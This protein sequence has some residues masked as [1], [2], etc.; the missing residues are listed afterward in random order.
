MFTVFD[1]LL[2]VGACSV[3]ILLIRLLRPADPSLE[4]Y[5]YL[6]AYCGPAGISVFGPWAVRRQFLE[7][8]REQLFPGEW[9][10]ITLGGAWLAAAPM[11]V[12]V[13][14]QG[15]EFFSGLV[16]TI[17]AL[18]ALVALLQSI[19]SERGKPWTHWTG[20]VLC[21]THATPSLKGVMPGIWSFLEEA[22]QAVSDFLFTMS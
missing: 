15:V 1:M 16:A 2:F 3:S 11:L 20:I 4:D 17:T 12:L 10:W 14:G 9:L 18:P 21:L 7:S 13:R 19:S 8:G 22:Y 5:L 6:S